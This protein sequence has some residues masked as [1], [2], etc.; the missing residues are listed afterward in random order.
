LAIERSRS[1]RENSNSRPHK[2]V[3]EASFKFGGTIIP[4][5]H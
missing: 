4:V 1:P 3:W 5:L 2:A